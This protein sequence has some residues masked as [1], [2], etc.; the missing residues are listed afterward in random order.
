MMRI[1]AQVHDQQD[2]L[3]TSGEAWLLRT[4]KTV[5]PGFNNNGNSLCR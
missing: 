3:L 4:S 1:D 2:V 5:I